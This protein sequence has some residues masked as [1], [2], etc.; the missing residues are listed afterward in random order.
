MPR[1]QQHVRERRSLRRGVPAV[2]VERGIRFGDAFR[3]HLRQR[4]ANASPVLERRQD[5]IRRAVDDAAESHDRDGR[6]RL[7]NEIEHRHAVHHRAFEQERH[8][9]ARGRVAR[10]SPIGERG[11][12]LVRRDDVAAGRERALRRDRSPA[13]PRRCR[14]SSFR[15][16]REAGCAR[17]ASASM[18][19]S[20][21]DGAAA[22]PSADRRP[23]GFDES[24]RPIAVDAIR[25]YSAPCRRVAMPTTRHVEVVVAREAS[26][27]LVEQAGEPS[28]DVAEADEREINAHRRTRRGMR[29]EHSADPLQ[30]PVRCAGIVAET[31]AQV[32][33]HLEVIAGHDEDALLRRAGA[34][35]ALS[36]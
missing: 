25:A 1:V 12:S 27:P 13:A 6:Q 34:R 20:A 3:L 35:R 29:V 16:R 11:R 36:N 32:A 19:S 10:S 9:A 5:V 31:D 24:P 28:A 30:A 21:L 23:A 8:T 2:D 22:G 26:A 15:R 33:V 18:Q 14:A 7:A 17:R 4:G